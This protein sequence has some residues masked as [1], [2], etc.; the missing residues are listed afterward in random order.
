MLTGTGVPPYAGADY[1]DVLRRLVV[2]YKDEGR[3]GLAERLGAMLA[4]V[5]AHALAEASG[6]PVPGTTVELVPVPSSRASVRRRGRDPAADLARSAARLLRRQGV[7][8][9][10]VPR[11]THRRTVRDQAGL[12][13]IE[14][15]ANLRGAL[16]ARPTAPGAG[17]SGR[18]GTSP[19]RVVVDDVVT[20]GAT[21]DE[22]V[23]VL[24]A[25]GWS[26]SA[27]AAVAAT[28]RWAEVG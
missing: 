15:A 2:A 27:V 20:T 26:V 4:E 10:V 7:D 25:A 6:R 24:L 16:Y 18:P 22:C 12:G 23:R 9:R 1:A 14:R 17:D 5:V 3:A 13:A 21:A 28:R 19:V 11:L 8:V